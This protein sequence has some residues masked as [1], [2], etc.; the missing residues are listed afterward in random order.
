MSEAAKPIPGDDA[1]GAEAL[2]AASDVVHFSTGEYLFYEGEP[3]DYAY[4][5][6]E[7]TLQLT[8]ETGRGPVQLKRLRPGELI[9]EMGIIDGSPRSASAVA[10]T[11][12]VARRIDV[13]AFMQRL[14]ADHQF[15]VDIIS[16]LITSLR[17]TNTRLAHQHF[18]NA[19][20]GVEA[21]GKSKAIRASRRGGLF[22]FFSA[23]SDFSEFQADAVE[24]ERRRFPPIAKF[25]LYFIIAFFVLVIAW[26]SIAEIETAV[27]APGNITTSV[28]NITVQPVETA[29]VLS[30]NAREGDV[31][32]KGQILATLDATFAQADLQASRATL[33]SVSAQERRL[34]A[35][36]SGSGDAN[37]SEHVAVQALQQEIFNRRQ[38]ELTANIAQKDQ[39]TARLEADIDTNIQDARDMAEQLAVLTELESMHQSLMGSGGSS[40]VQY[41]EAKNGR[42][43]LAREQRR[44]LSARR[45]LRHELEAAKAEK[46]VYLSERRARMAQELVSVSREREELSERLKKMERRERLVQIVAPARG[47]VLEIA[48]RS[49]G[50]VVQQAETFFTIVPADVPLQMEVNIAP[51][52]VGQVKLG[53]AV[54]VKLDALPF[55]KHGSMEGEV[56]LISEDTVQ[57]DGDAREPVYRTRIDLTNTQFRSTPENFRLIPGMT[58]TAEVTVG[59]RLVITY[60]FYPIARALEN[61]FK[62]P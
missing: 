60:F 36:L 3:S 2:E 49:V 19:E 24:I 21:G 46:Q 6:I 29:M 43:S 62:E 41:L 27:V 10:E 45:S 12:V 52:D 58:G 34:M 39:R 33:T 13:Y 56:A 31:V 48:D 8:K 20:Q 14:E 38:A 5:V 37:F 35:E 17:E 11:D 47:V 50:S 18:L 51:R 22:S 1:Q 23:N 40:R 53:D 59:K 15:T 16:R 26:A 25:T 44:L 55:Q 42:L 30:I 28:P 7:G 32:E 9:G 4:E 54:R 61:S 57:G